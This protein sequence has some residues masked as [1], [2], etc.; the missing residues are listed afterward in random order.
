[1]NIPM[2]GTGGTLAAFILHFYS[3]ASN[4]FLRAHEFPD[5]ASELTR[6]LSSIHS[7]AYPAYLA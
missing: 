1:M 3:T 5:G 2:R 6:R 7:L 4:S